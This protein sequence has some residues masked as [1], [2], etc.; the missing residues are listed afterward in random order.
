MARSN[1]S[2]QRIHSPILRYGLSI[3]CVAIALGLALTLQ[4]YQFSRVPLP[5]LSLAVAI[6]SWYAGIGPSVLAVLLSSVGFN[7]FFYFPGV[8]GPCCLVQH[9]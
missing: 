3:V 6:V 4:N 8:G 7:Y 9:R 1:E 5:F 2:L